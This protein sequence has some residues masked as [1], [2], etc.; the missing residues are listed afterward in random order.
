[1][2]S[3]AVL[4]VWLGVQP[5]LAWPGLFSDT[6]HRLTLVI[7][8]VALGLLRF[9]DTAPH[10]PLPRAICWWA[11]ALLLVMTSHHWHLIRD[12]A[13][14][15]FFQETAL[16]S[17]GVL[18]AV[19]VVWGFWALRQ[20]PIAWF[21]LLPWIGVA[22]CSINLILSLGQANGMNWHIG[23]PHP[24]DCTAEAIARYHI[25]AYKPS[26]FL[27]FDRVLGAY[28]VAWLPIL[29]LAWRPFPRRQWFG[30]LALIP[31][32]CIILASKVTTWIGVAV[33]V[34]RLCDRLIWRLSGCALA[35]IAAVRYS[36]GSFLLK[37]PMRALT[38]L[39]TAQGAGTFWWRGA[40]FN[41][42]AATSIRQ[43][44]GYALPGLH[45]DWLA[46]AFHAGI[47]M[48]VSAAC[49]VVWLVVQRPLTPMAGALQASVAA[50]AVMSA[51]QSVVSQSQLSGLIMVLVAWLLAE[52][53]QGATT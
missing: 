19:S 49:Y 23:T 42:L 9:G 20:V 30:P 51:G 44:F 24:V 31:I 21:R 43:Q 27:G 16:F 8:C 6:S 41:P 26:G 4:T 1:M 35:L 45:S 15:E 11:A 36:D 37:I 22:L 3:A 38:W 52:Q 48:A 33:V 5:W 2:W 25:S 17:D 32:V 29:W 40:G 18:L 12:A 14:F 10:R 46:L 50:I 7:C 13:Y 28:S 39:H 53:E 34:W 47:V